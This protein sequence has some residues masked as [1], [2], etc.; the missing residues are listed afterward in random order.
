MRE[1]IETSILLVLSHPP[2]AG[3]TNKATAIEI[4]ASQKTV[5]FHLANIYKKID[6]HA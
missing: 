2:L 1:T 4:A 6:A 5:E 3:K